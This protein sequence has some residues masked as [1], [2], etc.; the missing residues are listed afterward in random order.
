[1][2]VFVSFLLLVVAFLVLNAPTAS[3]A[4]RDYD[5]ADFANQAEAEEYLLPGDP[6]NLDAD[7]DGIACEDLPCPCSSTPGQGA[8]GGGNA[9]GGGPVEFPPPPP[10]HLKKAV[11]RH[12]ALQVVRKFAR[13]RSQ[14]D[15]AEVEICERRS[16]RR[17]VCFGTAEGESANSRTL[18][19][20]RV[21]V[22]AVDRQPKATLGR[23]RCTTRST[24][25]LTTARARSALRTRG[26]EI[27]G[28][29]VA[30][31]FLER[32]SRTSF[33]GT[34]EWT[35]Q[36]PTAAKTKEECSASMEAALTSSNQIG[37]VVIET[38]C[39]GQPVP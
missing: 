19:H 11:A 10:Y 17:V 2:K 26:A 20:L 31:G 23:A 24:V 13:H 9:G 37:V 34:A 5:C 29:P 6:Y 35:Q 30:L 33:Q 12:A 28:K 1:M 27:A 16:E 14:V 4:F 25:M 38:G 15:E 36:S 39:E 3:A 18:C 8:G 22:R 7:N 21:I 32:R